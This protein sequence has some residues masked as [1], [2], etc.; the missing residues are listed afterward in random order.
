MVK[1]GITFP[2]HGKVHGFKSRPARQT[3]ETRFKTPLFIVVF[4]S[5]EFLIGFCIYASTAFGWFYVMKHVKLGTLGVFYSISTVL[6]LSLVGAIFFK[7]SFNAY[8]IDGIIL[9]VIA[10]IELSRF[11]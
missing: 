7:E 2:C 6:F 11:S 10:L 4:F 3:T 1:P 8:E 9:A 5:Y